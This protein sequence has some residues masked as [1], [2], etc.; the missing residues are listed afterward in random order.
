M[1]T[2]MKTPPKRLHPKQKKICI[3]KN[4]IDD[5]EEDKNVTTKVKDAKY[6]SGDENDHDDGKTDKPANAAR[7]IYEDESFEQKNDKEEAPM[8]V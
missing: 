6:D 3:A 7:Y 1:M 8:K 2:K 4:D 5:N